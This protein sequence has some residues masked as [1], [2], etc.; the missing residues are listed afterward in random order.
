MLMS[1][2]IVS[3]MRMIMHNSPLAAKAETLNEQLQTAQGLV[4][5]ESTR[6]LAAGCGGRLPLQRHG[7]DRKSVV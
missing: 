7:T 1:N 3:E 5:L 4:T 2:A 6:L